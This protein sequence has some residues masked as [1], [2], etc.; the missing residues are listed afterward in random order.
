MNNLKSI[1]ESVAA[2]QDGMW[3]VHGRSVEVRLA[4]RGRKQSVY[5]EREGK[6]YLFKSVVLGAAAVTKTTKRWNHLALLS[7]LYNAEHELVTFAFDKRDRLIGLIRH[8]AKW[9]DPEELDLYV[10]T[11]ARDCD[12]FEYLLRGYDKF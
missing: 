12:R 10:S 9:L 3:T 8:P 7:W 2:K 6:Y 4:K 5:F 1:L 11:L